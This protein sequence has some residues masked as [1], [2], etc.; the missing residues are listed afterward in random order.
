MLEGRPGSVN[1][2]KL[3]TR[4]DTPALCSVRIGAD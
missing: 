3:D 4:K 1:K 2:I